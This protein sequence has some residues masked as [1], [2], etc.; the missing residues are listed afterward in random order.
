MERRGDLAVQYM[1]LF[2]RRS[3]QATTMLNGNQ[4]GAKCSYERLANSGSCPSRFDLGRDEA[5]APC[6]WGSG[7]LA[8]R[9]DS[10]GRMLFVEVLQRCSAILLP[11]TIAGEG[12]SLQRG[13]MVVSGP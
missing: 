10:G 8:R 11:E 3:F 5:N 12:A 1:N 6:S 7:F 9:T 4:I 2:S 13:S